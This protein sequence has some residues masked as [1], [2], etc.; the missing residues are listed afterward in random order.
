MGGG[1]T[2]NQRQ[3]EHRYSCHNGQCEVVKSMTMSTECDVCAPV[4]DPRKDKPRRNA[5]WNTRS[6]QTFGRLQ[7][8]KHLPSA[9]LGNRRDSATLREVVYIVDWEH[10]VHAS[11]EVQLDHVG[12]AKDVFLRHND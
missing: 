9:R 5:A 8:V 3:L 1:R 2:D 7:H 6:V 4:T 11:R 10:C 12:G